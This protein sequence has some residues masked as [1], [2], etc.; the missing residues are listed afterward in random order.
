MFSNFVF[1]LLT[2][3]LSTV[4]NSPPIVTNKMLRFLRIFQ[5]TRLKVLKSFNPL[6]LMICLIY[7]C[8]AH[9]KAKTFFSEF[10]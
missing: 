1:Q 4:D 10:R 9:L 5:I 3:V 8:N 2:T 7:L 6:T